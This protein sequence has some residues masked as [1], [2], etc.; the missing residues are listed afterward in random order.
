MRYLLDRGHDTISGTILPGIRQELGSKDPERT[1]GSMRGM[2]EATEV[3]SGD[4]GQEYRVVGVW[5]SP[6]SF[7]ESNVVGIANVGGKRGYLA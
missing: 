4:G 3:V 7:P 6:R 2:Y 1:Q 5:V